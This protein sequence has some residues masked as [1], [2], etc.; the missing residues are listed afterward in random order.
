MPNRKI[1]AEEID[2][3]L[4]RRL[5]AANAWIR[6]LENAVQESFDAGDPELLA[7]VNEQ[8]T[9]PGCGDRKAYRTPACRSC[10]D[11]QGALDGEIERHGLDS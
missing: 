7:D 2:S 6:E 1:T 11:V 3:E 9:C 5:N 4:V 10:E 8:I